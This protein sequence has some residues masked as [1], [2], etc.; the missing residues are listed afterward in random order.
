MMRIKSICIVLLAVYF[1][2]PIKGTDILTKS[3]GGLVA[4]GVVLVIWGFHNNKAFI[5]TRKNQI[6]SQD[7]EYLIVQT[8]YYNE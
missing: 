4:E 7:D 8:L 1:L 3:S 2:I 5:K 6:I